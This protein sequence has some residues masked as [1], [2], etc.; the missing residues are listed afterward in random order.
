MST[1][2][3]QNY[4]KCVS[5]VSFTSNEHKALNA[6]INLKFNA[7]ALRRG[8]KVKDMVDSAPFLF[9]VLS[10]IVKNSNGWLQCSAKFD[11]LVE[12]LFNDVNFMELVQRCLKKEEYNDLCK[13]GK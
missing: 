12:D 5:R 4:S 3:S 7:I 6:A 2:S 9:W 10:I 1:L 13:L 8:Q 11:K